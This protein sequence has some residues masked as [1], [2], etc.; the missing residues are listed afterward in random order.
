[1]LVLTK[2]NVATILRWAESHPTIEVT[3][4]VAE[5]PHGQRV[6][7]MKNIARRPEAYYE[8]DPKEMVTAWAL[9]D[10]LREEPLAYYHSH[11]N[12]RPDP[13][14]R[15]ME[16][17]LHEG[18]YHLIVY[19]LADPARY[20]EPIWRLSAWECIEPG[21]LMESRYEVGS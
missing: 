20:P 6:Q 12:G 15:D 10:D 7:P 3:G 19:P 17:A 18:I 2:D 13:S 9:M 11:P 14:E 16:G 5:G 8:W 21:I 4:L 1:M